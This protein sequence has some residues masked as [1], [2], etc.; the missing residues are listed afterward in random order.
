MS[1]K[2]KNSLSIATIESS[3]TISQFMEKCNNN[4][5]A[6]VGKGGG[7]A[8]ATGKQ[9]DI[10]NPT[11]PKVP[12]HVWIK[13]YDY[14]D[15]DENDFKINT[16]HANLSENKYQE[17]HLI[18][19]QNGHVYILKIQP[20]TFE[21]APE[22]VFAMQTYN[23]GDV[24][25]GKN[26]YLHIAYSNSSDGTKDFITSQ[27]LNANKPS[28]T[29][30]L[31]RSA[32]S[33]DDNLIENSYAYIGVYSNNEQSSPLNPSYYTW[34]R[35]QGQQGLTG[36]VGPKGDKGDTGDT[37]PAGPAGPAGDNYTGH[38][39]AIDL[40]GDMSTFSLNSNR[41]IAYD[42][43][44]CEC[45][46]HAYYGKENVKLNTNQVSIKSLS[47]GYIIQKDDEN[48]IHI[49]YDGSYVGSITITQKGNEDNDVTFRF[50]PD[51]NF[52]FPKNDIIFSIHV[53]ADIYDENNSTTYSFTRDNVWVIKG[54][55][56]TFELEII[57]QYR[58]IKLFDG[59][60]YPEELSVSVYKTENGERETF[61]FS[62]NPNF[63]LLYK[64]YNVNN[65]T[66]YTGAVDT[67][68]VS[69][70]EFKVVKNYGATNEEIW[71][72][73]D[74][75][76]VADGKSVHY[77]HA[78][79]GNTESMMVL[80]T[81][82]KINISEDG[83]E[84][85]YCADIRNKDGYSITFDPK[86]YDGSEELEVT[87][88]N[89]GT[90]SEEI[91]YSNGTFV[92]E[93]VPETINGVK[94][95]TLKITKVPYGVEVIPMT[96]IVEAKTAEE[97][98]KSDS[99]SFNVYISTQSN[100][101]TLVPTKPS[102]NTSTG[103]SGDKIGCGVYKN[104]VQIPITDLQVNGLTLKY[105]V[106]NGKDEQE[107]KPYTEP[108]V[109][110][111]DDDNIKDE[112]TAS[113]VA[114]EF[115]LYYLSNEIVRAT[116]P[117]IKDGIDG[118]DGDSWQY[119]FCRSPKYPFERTGFSNPSTWTDNNKTDSN[120]ELLGDNGITDANWY[121]DH[122]GVSKEFKYEYQ[123]YRKWDKEN[124]CWG[125]YGE[126]TLYSNYGEDGSGYNAI[127]SNPVAII[128][129][130][131]D[132]WSVNEN[133]LNQ[134][135]STMVYLYNNTSNI[136]SNSNIT[137]TLPEDNEYVKNGNFKVSTNE[138]GINE[139]IFTPVVGDSIFNFKSNSQYKL[140]I[141]I[142]YSLGVDSNDDGITDHFS[143]TLNWTLSPIKGM[144]DVEVFV[145]KRI[146]NITKSYKHTFRVGYYLISNT[147]RKFIESSD[148]EKGNIKNY[149]IALTPDVFESDSDELDNFVVVDD[150]ANANFNFAKYGG[151]N[152][153]YVVLLDSNRNIIDYVNVSAMKDGVDGNSAMHLELLQD[154][155]AL[156]SN[157]NG[158]GVHVDYNED[159][160]SK[161]ILYNGDRIIDDYDNIEYS[162]RVNDLDV[163]GGISII[164][165]GEFE[166]SKDFIVGDTNIECIAT[167]N[168]NSF[169]KN[170]FIDLE[171]T[172]F[173]LE[174]NKN[175]LTRDV[176]L[177]KIKESELK[178]RVKFWGWNTDD[179]G[180][181]KGQWIYSDYGYIE[182]TTPNS[183]IPIRQKDEI[184]DHVR[185]IY[186]K[187]ST[188]SSDKD[189][190]EVRISYYDTRISDEEL[191]YETIG[192]IDCG[193][194]GENGKD[195]VTK[196]KSTVFTRS[197]DKPNTPKGGD[198]DSPYPVNNGSDNE[199]SELEDNYIWEDGIPEGN[200]PIWSSCRWFS[201]EEGFVSDWSQPVLMCDTPDF[202]VIYNSLE[203]ITNCN[204]ND[205]TITAF[206]KDVDGGIKGW[207][208]E[209]EK[210]FNGKWSDDGGTDSIWMA[211]IT[212]TNGKWG[213]WT[214]SKIKGEKGER[215]SAPSCVGVK[216]LGYSLDEL[217]INDSK[218]VKSLDD[219]STDSESISIGQKIYI[220]NEYTW[221]DG[222][223]TKGITV[224]LAGTQG[225]N[226]KSR[227]L[228]YLGSFEEGK[229]TLTDE[230]IMG[231]LT[232][233]RCDYYIDF[234][235]QAWM[236]IGQE[237]KDNEGVG[238]VGSKN[239]NDNS[240]NWQ[241]SEK[242][243][244]LQAG[245]ITAD[246][247]NVKN[248]VAS[249]AF[250][251]NLKVTNANI[252]EK[253]TAEQIDAT[254]LKVNAA[255][256]TGTLTIGSDSENEGVSLNGTLSS[257]NI[258]EGAITT[259]KIQDGAII[260]GKIA[261]NAITA[262]NIQANAITAGK[263]AANA[264]TADNISADA[265]KAFEIDASQ[266]KTGT[267]DAGHI[268]VDNLSVKKL[269][270][271]PSSGNALNSG[272]V[273][274]QDN[275]IVV[276]ENNSIKPVLK[277]SGDSI[278][279]DFAN[280]SAIEN[281][282]ITFANGSFSFGG[283]LLVSGTYGSD[284]KKR[285]IPLNGNNWYDSPIVIPNSTNNIY[286]RTKIY[287]DSNDN[288]VS[289]TI[290]CKFTIASYTPGGSGLQSAG[291]FNVGIQCI[292]FQKDSFNSP[293]A[294]FE[295][296]KLLAKDSIYIQDGKFYEDG[297]AVGSTGSTDIYIDIPFDTI[298]DNKYARDDKYIIGLFLVISDI[299]NIGNGS[300]T[301]NYS[302]TN[303]N[304]ITYKMKSLVSNMP[305]VNIYKDSF[306]YFIDDYNYLNIDDEGY[307]TY[308]GPG[309]ISG[310][311]V[312]K[313]DGVW[314]NVGGQKFK[315]SDLST[316]MANAVRKLNEN[317]EKYQ[318]VST[319]YNDIDIL[320]NGENGLIQKTLNIESDLY[321]SDGTSESPTSG[322]VLSRTTGLET[323][324][325]GSDGSSGSPTSGSV[326]V[327]LNS[328]SADAIEAKT[329]AATASVK[330]DDAINTANEA[331]TLANTNSATVKDLTDNVNSLNV[332]VANLNTSVSKIQLSNSGWLTTAISSD[333]STLKSINLSSI[334]VGV[335]PTAIVIPYKKTSGIQYTLYYDASG[336][337]INIYSG[338]NILENTY[339]S[340]GTTTFTD[341]DG[342]CTIIEPID[343]LIEIKTINTIVEGITVEKIT[344]YSCL[345]LYTSTDNTF[346]INVKVT[347]SDGASC[348]RS[349]T[350]KIAS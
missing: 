7:P 99:I 32:K 331:S 345:G 133:M 155:I 163:D 42:G 66:E 233:E 204:P 196:F 224:T 271:Q 145:D 239:G 21:L 315:L 9:G 272:Q 344:R 191:S 275:E 310:F 292:V 166:I 3:D 337:T 75:W 260:T 229:A 178:V 252:S 70:L 125:K 289:N 83:E 181:R 109:Y 5:S 317:A 122:K 335:A 262:D 182:A 169:Y 261:A 98:I 334:S 43:D 45:I 245:A 171:H 49:Q 242:V 127:L 264:I 189:I 205:D 312:N 130:G 28:T 342:N 341:S 103:K 325:Y 333:A 22:F 338:G 285:V 123:A 102:Y 107:L 256:I 156:P 112:F 79:L 81:G 67:N 213:N 174:V 65:W 86:F 48:K 283:N 134:M 89:I 62:K 160:K 258:G 167:Y 168:G 172:P 154:Y 129:V 295:Y 53:E 300:L 116:V 347:N 311:G 143:T 327:R 2:T 263:I 326:L 61:D 307:F 57:P 188:L 84:P 59:G 309:M 190:T 17:D 60:R 226:G 95:Y 308:Y 115:I 37:G 105:G 220:L 146:V 90:N 232:P 158:I 322:S 153:F 348:I 302:I 80:T 13:P 16:I 183:E 51:P 211:T 276:T 150:W 340:F 253:L 11:K 247:I 157:S 162:F 101:Y 324:L 20:D 124:K 268:D 265:I 142:T 41:N 209:N 222:N 18:M 111:T 159:I 187:D 197:V 34:I 321:G 259:T 238:V 27:E 216:I 251:D 128:P 284:D 234:N 24:I 293:V 152:N 164:G 249:D 94:K 282:T 203:D 277:I 298:C 23:P 207:L 288:M 12:I 267:I 68:N 25:D 138:N 58:T 323:D 77:Y 26:A 305:N 210:Y 186:I 299:T 4:F 177:G 250:V 85:K 36:A 192:I 161:M 236:R 137:I 223:V 110:G 92:R 114:I 141:T 82:E 349:L 55:V 87:S 71:D 206:Y 350:I 1:D 301:I 113:D 287:F 151:V 230:Y 217:D 76:A 255:N 185:T 314:F 44:Y 10:G 106:Y 320:I 241:K 120:S 318:T 39:Y 194:D 193:K 184:V 8:G 280:T 139:V 319:Q 346:T 215:G 254:N 303:E 332:D 173:E 290:E 195:G 248:L 118:K 46:A 52:S 208:K 257:D 221:S 140:P 15:E 132:D 63:K 200:E 88:V 199:D 100:V 175:V 93:L 274:I 74:V 244:F 313:D 54:I 227:V 269:N 56:S 294:S 147:S 218:W 328:A 40:E 149:S 228:F 198:F 235:G 304:P 279:D 97:E 91:Y 291:R 212:K 214:I 35:I 104:N 131:D 240:D 266:I 297:F 201:D 47:D 136:S 170:L 180:N 30:N 273:R 296:K 38:L 329:T 330:A 237:D 96:I 50:T 225:A 336:S 278:P 135:D 339:L 202:E 72:Y 117:L 29:F 121:D 176:N 281:K 343:D 119:I 69:C 64:N 78:D 73:E 219:L 316:D 144:E 165:N 306:R 243:G 14:E 33:G 270:T 108:I 231:H 126:P 19:L 179:N 148:P 6:I 246:M 31:K 286:S